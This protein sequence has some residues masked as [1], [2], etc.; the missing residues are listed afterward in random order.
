MFRRS[1]LSPSSGREATHRSST[2]IRNS[3][4]RAHVESH[5]QQTLISAAALWTLAEVTNVSRYWQVLM[6]HD[7]RITRIC[8]PGLQQRG[9]G[10][11]Q[12]LG[13]RQ[14]GTVFCRAQE[15][16]RSTKTHG[17]HTLHMAQLMLHIPSV[18]TPTPCHSF[19]W[20]AYWRCCDATIWWMAGTA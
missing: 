11:R 10:A 17:Q 12:S 19:G 4:Q 9:G 15:V 13:T 8:T 16:A 6:W 14:Q 1:V 3:A 5:G 18:K 2:V 20:V 7:C